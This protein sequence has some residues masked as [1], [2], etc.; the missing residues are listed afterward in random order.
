MGWLVLLTRRVHDGWITY[1]MSASARPQGRVASDRDRDNLY[2]IA[3]RLGAPDD[4]KTVL[5][6][7]PSGVY[8]WL[9]KEPDLAA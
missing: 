6:V 1:Q 7:S 2:K 4:G 8:H 3:K 9:W 5:S